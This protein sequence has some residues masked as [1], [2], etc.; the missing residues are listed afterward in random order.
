MPGMAVLAN[1][2]VGIFLRGKGAVRAGLVFRDLLGM[3]DAA[4][5]G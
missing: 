1:R 2:R 5:D 3:A 4:V